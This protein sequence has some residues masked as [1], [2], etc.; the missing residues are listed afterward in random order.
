VRE[1]STDRGRP[2]PAYFGGFV[3]VHSNYPVAICVRPS[4]RLRR[5]LD[6]APDHRIQWIWP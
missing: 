1:G 5:Y 3:G 4:I 2:A 6:E